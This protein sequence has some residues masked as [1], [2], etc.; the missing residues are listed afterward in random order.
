MPI[1]TYDFHGLWRLSPEALGE[2]GKRSFRL[3]AENDGGRAILWAEKQHL[4]GL[5]MAIYQMLSATQD[6]VPAGTEARQGSRAPVY[7]TLIM[8]T[9]RFE[10]GVEPAMSTPSPRMPSV[11]SSPPPPRPP[12]RGSHAGCSSARA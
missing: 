8:R 1:V 12:G 10:L 11:L 3:V 7:T 5:A 9:D 4:Q 6:A 2:P